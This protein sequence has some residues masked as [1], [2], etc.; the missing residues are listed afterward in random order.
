MTYANYQD[1][2]KNISTSN[3]KIIDKYLKGKESSKK[4]VR[5]LLGFVP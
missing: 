3:L 4:K 1:Y 5:K 2:Q